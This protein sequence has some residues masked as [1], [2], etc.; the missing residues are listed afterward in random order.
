MQLGSFIKSIPD[1]YKRVVVYNTY[2]PKVDSIRFIA[3][4]SVILCHV[5]V[6]TNTYATYKIHNHEIEDYWIFNLVQGVFLFFV[7]SGYLLAT[8]FFRSEKEISAPVLKKYY[9]RRLTRLEPPYLLILIFSFCVLVFLKHKYEF[10][11]LFPHFISSVFYSSN[12]VYPEVVMPLVL[13][14]AWTLE[15]EMQF[16]IIL[17][18]L[19]FLYKKNKTMSRIIAIAIIIILRIVL[20][21]YKVFTVSNMGYSFSYFVAGILLADII[22]NT[23]VTKFKKNNYKIWYSLL[24]IICI[25][26]L[27]RIDWQERYY[28]HKPDFMPFICILFFYLILSKNIFSPFFTNKWVSFIGGMCYSL[29]LTHF[30]IISFFGKFTLQIK[31]TEYYLINYCIQVILLLPLVLIGG[32]LFYRFIELPTMNKDWVKKIFKK[33]D[34]STTLKEG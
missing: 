6:H 31:F 25:L 10:S 27:W 13:P 21:K 23:D 18:F 32:F 5:F 8:T 11:F 9:L 1:K 24:G 16:Y 34:T 20:I 19:M 7:L 2:S 28:D 33:N 29:Y 30:I 12:L 4:I 3:I 22:Q 15:M 17:P 14:L 26:L